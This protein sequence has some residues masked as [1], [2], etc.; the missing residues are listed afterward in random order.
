MLKVPRPHPVE[1]NQSDHVMKGRGLCSGRSLKV[2]ISVLKEN[3]FNLL[4]NLKC[5]VMETQQPGLLCYC[6]I[7]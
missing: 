7:S 1:V 4:G 3:G 5:V 2:N 6:R